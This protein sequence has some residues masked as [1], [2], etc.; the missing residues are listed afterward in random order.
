MADKHDP[1]G[2]AKEAAAVQAVELAGTAVL[3]VVAVVL[4]IVQR[5]T[6]SPDFV[7]QLAVRARLWRRRLARHA[8]ARLA[9][10][11]IWALAQA[12]R[13]RMVADARR[14]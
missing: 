1:K 10:L 4:Q 5:E 13:Q 11:G 2:A 12:E 14:I 3:I 8:E 7:P 9:R 6:S